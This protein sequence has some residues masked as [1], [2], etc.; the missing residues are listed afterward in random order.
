MTSMD[1]SSTGWTSQRLGSYTASSLRWLD[2][3]KLQKIPLDNLMSPNDESATML[4]LRRQLYFVDLDPVV[5]CEIGG[6]KM[7]P[8]L[9]LSI[10]DINRKPLTVT[11]VPGTKAAGKK[12][13]FRNVITVSPTMENGLACDTNFQCH[14]VRALD[15]RRFTK[16]AIGLLDSWSMEQISAAVR[17][18]LGL[19]FRMP[20][21]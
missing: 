4:I 2:I 11:V 3:L 15:H 14:Q 17:Y 1:W 13:G 10:D 5:G 19:D 12:T 7:R 20:R 8:V 16:P 9:V 6:G 21:T 18:T